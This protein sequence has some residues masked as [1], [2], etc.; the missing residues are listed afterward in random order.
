M[1]KDPKI[2]A[3]ALRRC[4]QDKEERRAQLERRMEEVY[5]R[6]PRVESIDRELRGTVADI[7]IAAFDN[8]RDP[9]PALK[10][11]SAHNLELPRERSEL[12]VGGG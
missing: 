2:M 3:A 5:R 11:L 10:A 4:Q 12:L 8:D 1:A 9:A 6:L 7:M